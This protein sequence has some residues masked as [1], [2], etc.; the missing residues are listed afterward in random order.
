MKKLLISLAAVVLFG[1]GCVDQYRAPASP[2]QMPSATAPTAGPSQPKIARIEMVPG[3]YNPAEL[4]VEVGTNV[5]FENKDSRPRWPASGVHATHEICPGFD[6]LGSVAP[7][8]IF[9][10]I[11]TEKKTCPFHDHFTPNLK[12]KLIVR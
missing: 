4:E 12:G 6:P 3:G 5:V 9:S 1:A 11:F 10:H 7:G 2:K 8:S